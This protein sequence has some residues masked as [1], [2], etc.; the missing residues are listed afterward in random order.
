MVPALRNDPGH[1]GEMNF[2][3]SEHK[4]SIRGP[5]RR[6]LTL[7]ACLVALLPISFLAAGPIPGPQWDART[8]DGKVLS[9]LKDDDAGTVSIVKGVALEPLSLLIDLKEP[10]LVYRVFL[11]GGRPAPKSDSVKKVQ[12]QATDNLLGEMLGEEEGDG[13]VPYP[14]ALAVSVRA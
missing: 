9:E 8:S 12:T 1:R 7:P 3:M 4:P 6:S 5:R 14:K 10:R 11:T 13:P 2:S